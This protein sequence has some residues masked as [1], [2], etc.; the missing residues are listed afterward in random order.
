MTSK[1]PVPEAALEQLT[2][3]VGEIAQS[4]RPASYDLGSGWSAI[5]DTTYSRYY[6]WHAATGTVTWEIPDGLSGVP[7]SSS[8]LVAAP[9]G[10]E[11]EKK[12]QVP[13]EDMK[14]RRK[15]RKTEETATTTVPAPSVATSVAG[16]VPLP[17]PT[18]APSFSTVNSTFG[19]YPS[20]KGDDPLA[21]L[22]S[23]FATI[24]EHK[25]ELDKVAED[26]KDE[27]KRK[28]GYGEVQEE[29]KLDASSSEGGFR[30]E[31]GID[32]NNIGD[33]RGETATAEYGQYDSSYAPESFATYAPATQASGDYAY[34]AKFDK[35][36]GRMVP[37]QLA[38]DPR[39]V[40]PRAHFS[41]NSRAVRQMN[42]FFDYESYAAEVQAGTHKGANRLSKKE[43]EEVKRRAKEKK[44]KK[45]LQK[46][47]AGSD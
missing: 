43:L 2:A 10:E 44:E 22:E 3:E 17:L 36:T 32:R 30:S 8:E 25:D 28:R 26:A 19:A 34:S 46:W 29:P 20:I 42:V 4:P 38:T 23:L 45:I 39:F 6:Y 31:F 14:Q 16:R 5:L 33:V 21:K 7:E 24:D 35:R 27:L 9:D 1:T 47:G 13:E 18:P 37:T 15:K 40:D 12:I 11:E 41:D